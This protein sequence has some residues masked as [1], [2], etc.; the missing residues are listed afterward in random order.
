M[1][2]RMDAAFEGT[3]TC[4]DQTLKKKHLQMKIL[5]KNEI[6]GKMKEGEK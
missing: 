6:K 5:R 3:Y 4:T 1:N 2:E